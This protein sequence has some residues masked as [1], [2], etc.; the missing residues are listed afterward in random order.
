VLV[1][2]SRLHNDLASTEQDV[3]SARAL[4][5]TL[6]ARD[7]DAP[8]G[9]PH[10]AEPTDAAPDVAALER[11]FEAR[12]PE[13]GAR[14][15][16]VDASKARLDAAKRTAEWARFTVGVDYMLMPMME[17]PHAYAAMLSMTLPWLNPAHRERVRAAESV[18]SADEHSLD[19][20]RDIARYELR[21]AAARHE[22][23]RR[24]FA[25]V[26]RDVL[27]QA[28]ASYEAAE[29]AFAVGGGDALGVIDAL[30]AYLEVR[31]ERTRA[32][33]RLEESLTDLERAA[34]GDLD[35]DAESKGDGS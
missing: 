10:A 30:R 21:A 6:M 2:L 33:V 14:R 8:L 35:A 13:L 5:N 15:H 18:V 9:P 12:R 28:R 25:I 23:A 24:S 22:A 19:A 31:I 3:G 4:L 26:D 1:Q 17:D 16:A 29:A 27:P 34:G 20:A 32:L 7:P 11:A